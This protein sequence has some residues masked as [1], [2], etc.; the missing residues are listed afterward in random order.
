[1]AV[2]RENVVGAISKLAARG[3]FSPFPKSGKACVEIGDGC[4][5][6]RRNMLLVLMWE[7]CNPSRG[8][9]IQRPPAANPNP[10]PCYPTS[11]LQ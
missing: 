5:R 6:E 2:G 3:G 1:M 4:T 11:P 9:F 10:K 8:C 7:P